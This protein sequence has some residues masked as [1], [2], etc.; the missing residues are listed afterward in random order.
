[1][2][3]NNVFSEVKIKW[4]SLRVH[5]NKALLDGCLDNQLKNKLK[6]KIAYHEMK[7]VHLLNS[8]APF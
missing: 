4:H 2:K 6:Q 3:M 5:Y 7:M 1:M 8:R